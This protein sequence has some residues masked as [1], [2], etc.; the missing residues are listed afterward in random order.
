MII[1][2]QS[3]VQTTRRWTGLHNQFNLNLH[4]VLFMHA[5][6]PEYARCALCHKK[7]RKDFY[8]SR[9][10]NNIKKSTKTRPCQTFN[11]AERNCITSS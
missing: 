8:D 2:Q 7:H 1:C 11:A 10:K 5:A 3:I 9:T 4:W 6:W